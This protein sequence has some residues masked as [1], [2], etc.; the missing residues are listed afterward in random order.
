MLVLSRKV[1]EEIVIGDN[2]HLMV[3]AIQ[4]AKVRIGISA[5]K[6]VVVDRQEVYEE[7]C[8]R[9]TEDSTSMTCQPNS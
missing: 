7:R 2:I 9:L 3:V 8:Q 6:D 4:G 5:P 1:G